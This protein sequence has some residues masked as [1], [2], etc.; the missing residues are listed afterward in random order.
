MCVG[1]V[2]LQLVKCFAMGRTKAN[3]NRPEAVP[4]IRREGYLLSFSRP[5]VAPLAMA[6]CGIFRAAIIVVPSSRGAQSA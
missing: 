2:S 6:L 5:Q 1:V 4:Q 3:V